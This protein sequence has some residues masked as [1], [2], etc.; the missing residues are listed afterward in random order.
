[1]VPTQETDLAEVVA[2]TQIGHM[3]VALADRRRPPTDDH[4]FVGEGALVGE[5]L[6]GGEVAIL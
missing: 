5:V 6:A 3:S 2:G 1:M 4:E